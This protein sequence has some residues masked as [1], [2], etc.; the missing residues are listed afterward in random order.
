MP[1]AGFGASG[2]I[3]KGDGAEAAGMTGAARGW[4]RPAS[5]FVG[6]AAGAG[7]GAA[8]GAAKA[9]GP[10]WAA[11]AEGGEAGAPPELP[12]GVNE[13]VVVAGFSGTAGAEAKPDAGA[14]AAG[15]STAGC[16]K[17]LA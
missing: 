1:G 12:N 5:A 10:G 2:A 4:V 16:A 9:E 13:M 7:C 6:A 14:G 17:G 8:A 3:G 15:A 11:A